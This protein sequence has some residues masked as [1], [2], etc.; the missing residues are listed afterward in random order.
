MEKE[1]MMSISR[2]IKSSLLLSLFTSVSFAAIEGAKLPDGFKLELY[3]TVDGARS[4]ALAPDGTLFV[5]NRGGDS[6][7]AVLD[8]NKDFKADKVIKLVSGLRMPNGVAFRE[9]K[10]YVAT[11]SEIL[12][13]ENILGNLKENA[14]YKKLSVKFPE[15]GHHGWKYIAFSPE[16]NLVVPVGAPCNVCDAGENYSGIFSVDLKTSKVTKIASGVRNTVGFDWHPTTGKLW[17]TE[18][19]RDMMGDDIPEEEINVLLKDGQHFGY[20]YCHAGMLKDPKFGEGVDCAKY[21]QP[22]WKLPAHRAPLGMEFYKGKMFPEKYRKG[23]FIAEHGSWNRSTPDGYRITFV[24]VDGDKA[25]DSFE[26]LGG[27]L[28]GRRR[29]ARPVDFETL[30]DGS[31]LF[32]C[33]YNGKIYRITYKGSGQ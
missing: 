8:T 2:L 33:D 9:G 4:L 6:V 21:T 22:A 29:K 10:L 1:D 12:V 31:L 18:N 11:V 28:E 19:G 23:A 7:Y 30:S 24:T 5:G 16:G 17:F 26:F 14:P 25:T 15:D 32:S 3:A 27:L 13:F 20:P